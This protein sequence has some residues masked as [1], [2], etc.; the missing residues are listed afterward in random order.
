MA[1]KRTSVAFDDF[2]AT[3]C[4]GKFFTWSLMIV[5]WILISDGCSYKS[6]LNF[7]INCPAK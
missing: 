2:S 6:A 5:L 1:S 4:R 3:Y 7:D